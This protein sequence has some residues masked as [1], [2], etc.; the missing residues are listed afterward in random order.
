MGRRRDG[1]RVPRPPAAVL[2][3]RQAGGLR[4]AGD[5]RAEPV[6]E[7]APKSS[8][9][10]SS[11]GRRR[12]RG[13]IRV[14]AAVPPRPSSEEDLHG[15]TRRPR[16][17]FAHVDEWAAT[18]AARRRARPAWSKRD[19]RVFW[20]GSVRSGCNPGNVARLAALRLTAARPDL[21]DARHVG[22]FDPPDASCAPNATARAAETAG[23]FVNASDFGRWRAYSRRAEILAVLQED[24]TSIRTLQK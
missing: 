6:P 4:R 24:S 5:P 21:F 16:R 1:P 19:A 23:G 11:F 20:R 2:R 14:A 12:L 22:K 8:R 7:A 13:I 3:H 18:C 17:Y 10:K 9:E 15:I